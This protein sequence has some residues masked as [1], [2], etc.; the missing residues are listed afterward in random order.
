MASPAGAGTA[1]A[2]GHHDGE[3]IHVHMDENSG[4][5][6]TDIPNI[7]VNNGFRITSFVEE[8]VNLETAFMRLTKGMVQ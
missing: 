2:F 3:R 6:V 7:L 4:T 1:G 8:A 5:S